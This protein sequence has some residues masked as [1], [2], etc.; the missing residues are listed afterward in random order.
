LR[1]EFDH[2][3]LDYYTEL[4]AVLLA[5]TEPSS[6]QMPEIVPV[7]D[8]I[9]KALNSKSSPIKNNQLK[10]IT[11]Q[12]KELNIQAFSNDVSRL[13]YNLTSSVITS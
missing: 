11:S 10:D 13:S 4:D 3:R 2:S 8:S 9:N 6:W 1:L 12:I 5:G 7:R